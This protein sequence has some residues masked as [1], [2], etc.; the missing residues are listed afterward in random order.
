[1]SGLDGEPSCALGVVR[2]VVDRAQGEDQRGDH[3]LA[4]GLLDHA[5]AGDVRLGIV[6]R[7]R[8]A[9]AAD[10]VSRQDPECERT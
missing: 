6:H 5:R 2:V 10:A 9:E 8:Q 3:V 4:A 1:M 7:I